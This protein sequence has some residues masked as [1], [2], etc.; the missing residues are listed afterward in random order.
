MRS[1]LI[2]F[3]LTSIHF[4]LIATPLDSLRLAQEGESFYIVHQVDPKE[5]L[6]SLSRRYNVP[7]QEILNYNPD[8]KS[9]LG[10]GSILKIPYVKKDAV[11]SSGGIH[12]VKPS[13][14]LYYISKLYKVEAVDIKLW[15]GL[16]SNSL[17][18]GQKL[19]I[20][21]DANFEP[22]KI[23]HQVRAGETLFSIAKSYEVSVDEIKNWNKLVDN[24][25]AI[26]QT[27][28]VG[29]KTPAIAS[30]KV[31]ATSEDVEPGKEIISEEDKVTEAVKENTVIED[32]KQSKKPIAYLPE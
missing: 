22:E 10:V 6:Y 32:D 23:N 5:T 7:I 17:S 14:T 16:R 4:S 3:L 20:K 27:L 24:N 26:G 15:N 18:V 21:K 13:E 8:S 31:N 30:S 2:I 29:F 19:I 11:G 1:G 12:V 28:V 9:G 25:L